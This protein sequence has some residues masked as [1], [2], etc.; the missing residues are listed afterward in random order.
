MQGKK[1]LLAAALSLATLSITPTAFAILS[2]PDGWYLEVNGGSTDSSN[3]SYPG[4]VSSSGLGGNANVGYKFMPYFGMELGYTLYANTVI[5]TAT[6]NTKAA[7]V[8]VYSYDLAAR[9]ILPI[10]SSGFELFA[11]VGIQRLN[12][13]FTIKNA[14]AAA[15]LGVSNSSP[16]AVGLYIGGGAQYYFIPE[17]AVNMQWMRAQGNS[18][19]GNYELLSAGIS[20]IL[21]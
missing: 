5:K 18:T 15:A 9:G 21:D 10:S 4:N 11:K 14:A 13:S 12:E 8:K 3:T 17:L 20:F 19:T 2:V 16:S 1:Y 7:E 6:G